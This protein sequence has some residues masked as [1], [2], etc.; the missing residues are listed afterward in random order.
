MGQRRRLQLVLGALVALLVPLWPTFGF[1]LEGSHNSFAQFPR[2]TPGPNGSLELEFK[3][4]EPNGLLMYTD[5]GGSYE[6]F[7]LKL[8]DG[9]ARLRYNLGG[10]ARMVSVG[11]GLNDG[12]WHKVRVSRIFDKTTLTVDDLTDFKITKSVDR[13]FGSPA[14]NSMVFVGGLPEEV[15]RRPERALT[16]P[17]VILEP[18]FTGQVGQ[19]VYRGPNGIPI[20]QDMTASQGVRADDTG[21]VCDHHDP[22]LNMGRCYS[23]DGT[24]MCDCRKVNRAG[25]YCEKEETPREATFRGREF[26]W[27]DLRRSGGEPLASQ[28]DEITLSFKTRHPAGLLFFTGDGKDYMNVALKEGRVLVTVDMGG[29]PLEVN[30]R[31]DR[32]RFDDNQWHTISVHRRVKEITGHTSFCSLSVSVDGLFTERGT[33]AG[34][35]SQLSSSRLHVAGADH[36][37][38]LPGAKTR[39]NFVGCL[40]KVIY[41]ADSVVLDLIEMSL[42]GNF[43]L[44]ASGQLEYMCQEV[45]AADPVSFTTAESYL[46]GPDNGVVMFTRPDAV[47]VLPSWEAPRQGSVSFKIRTTEP[48]GLLLYNS[49]ALSAQGDFF[50]LELLEGHVYL[51]LNLGS[52]SRRVKA[53]NRRI[54][55]G[56]WHE[57]TLNRDAKDGRITVD[58]VANDFTTPG[59]S[60]QL[61]LEGALYVGGVG[62]GMTVP[63]ELWSGRLRFGYV[64]CMRDLV[65]N[66]QV[67][68][69]ASYAKRQDSGSIV[70][71][72]HSDGG[73]CTST[74]CMHGGSCSQ[75]WGRFICDCAHTSFVGPTCGKEASTLS[76]DGMQYLRM[77]M[78][79]ESRTQAEDISLRFK[80]SRPSGLLLATTT[81]MSSDKLELALHSGRV[82]LT[83]KLG[84]RD[85]VVHAGHG[86]NDDQW[87]TVRFSRRAIQLTLRVDNESPQLAHTMGRHS[88]LEYRHV[89]VA[90]IP[91][92]TTFKFSSSSGSSNSIWRNTYGGGPQAEVLAYNPPF[93]GQMQNLILNGAHLFEMARTGHIENMEVT[94]KFGKTS[95]VV[96]H[97]VTFKSAASYVSLPQLKAYSSTNIYFQFKT[98]QPS[99]L[100]MY[101]PGKV[102]DFIAIELINGHVNLVFNLGSGPVRMRDNNKSTLNDNRWHA[103]TVGRPSPKQHTLMVDDRLATV[104]NAGSTENLDLHGNLYLGGVRPDMYGDLPRHINSRTGFEGCIASL[105]LNGESPDPA[106]KDVLDRSTMVIAGC[107][108]PRTKCRDDACANG[109]TCVQQW[110]SY[111]CN[112]DMTSYTGPT[113]ADESTAYEFGP[114]SG[115]VTF[116]YPEGRWP[117]AHRDLLALGFMTTQDD[118]VILRL[119]SANSNDYMEL[120]IV[121]GNM[122]MV[123]NMGTE[124]HP[125]G[126]LKAKINDGLYHVVRFI[127]SGPNATIQLDDY[128]IHSKNP[129]EI[130][131]LS[132]IKVFKKLRSRIWHGHQLSVFNGQ[133]RMQIGGRRI[134]NT[135]SIDRPFMGVLS[136]VVLNGERPLDLAAERDPRAS[137][138]GDVRLLMRVPRQLSVRSSESLSAMHG[139]MPRLNPNPWQRTPAL[140]GPV[141]GVSDDLVFSGAGAGCDV[142]D[143]DECIPVFDT[144]SGDDLITPVYVAPT[145]PPASHHHKDLISRPDMSGG[146]DLGVGGKPCDDEEDCYIG[147]GSG[148]INTDVYG[149]T[150][151][152]AGEGEDSGMDMDNVNTNGP[153]LPPTEINSDEH[154]NNLAKTNGSPGSSSSGSSSGSS[155]SSG[156]SSSLQSNNSPIAQP[157][158][159]STISSSSTLFTSPTTT[160]TT[161]TSTYAPPSH[162]PPPPPKYEPE[163]YIYE[164]PQP[165]DEATPTREE[166]YPPRDQIYSDTAEFIALVIGI[167]A[168]ALIIVILIILLILKI[169][170]RGNGHYKVD[171]NKA[172][173]TY[174]GIPTGPTGHMANGHHGNGNIKPG[175]RRPVKKQSK[176]VKE[177]YV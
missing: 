177:W 138:E 1:I 164:Y 56:T 107:D 119:D 98:L 118:A 29:D 64:G 106:G 21:S 151:I 116:E 130:V 26:L 2:W 85:K 83:V 62:V 160:T 101:N 20:V 73:S 10:G 100:I 157:T 109:G 97:P 120:E 35:F 165:P 39:S 168:G 32:V 3:T 80:T 15:V 68:D 47:L 145:R 43:L 61:D 89:F 12:R 143:E 18:R 174:K 94:A 102:H 67:A 63:P 48:N 34:P 142:D 134:R 40:R 70:T 163:D 25:P 141:P 158:P 7:E 111:S 14:T 44:Q 23:S 169:K 58:E 123:Y 66:G 88:I 155:G 87:H 59:D 122:V 91:D 96:H 81:A 6:F 117:D 105:D 135:R 16:L 150:D 166:T 175:D 31:S 149:I 19:V 78:G 159:S 140:P 36:P 95:Q 27:W 161:T 77:S 90:F 38:L 144:G 125:L 113:C 176:D 146:M 50:A 121:E 4:R 33:T 154:N 112:C 76:F 108:G 53:T 57:V 49:G 13:E 99:G 72:C 45:K 55:D 127:R 115:V 69:L 54:D 167:V 11:Q 60:H 82:R 136:G 65:I 22:C 103:V 172:Y 86:L 30:V 128:D 42:S 9:A 79:E 137:V 93:I 162:N 139:N 171:E 133:S 92:N 126:E 28:A 75:G 170:G 37:A 8:V 132:D 24:A 41:R 71:W 131:D 148:E 147:S 5:D 156:S 129:K 114:G 17:V 173:N 124:D 74:P 46:D 152:D 153:L 51:Q 52:G 104:T 84:D 110:N